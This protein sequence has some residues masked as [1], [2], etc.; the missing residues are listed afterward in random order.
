[1]D[2]EN[3]I[4]LPGYIELIY[5]KAHGT[6]LSIRLLDNQLNA[7][8]PYVT[9]T[10]FKKGEELEGHYC[11]FGHLWEEQSDGVWRCPIDPVSVSKAFK[12]VKT[13]GNKTYPAVLDDVLTLGLD[14]DMYKL[15]S[16]GNTIDIELRHY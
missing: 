14:R 15:N 1:M 6:S 9:I 2:K 16:L 7:I 10:S 4:D 11:V 12:I 13:L 8:N 3:L 5:M